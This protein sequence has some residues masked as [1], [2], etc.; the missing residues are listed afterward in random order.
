MLRF[1]GKNVIDGNFTRRKRWNVLE[2]AKKLFL[3]WRE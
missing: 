1:S 3:L 2:I